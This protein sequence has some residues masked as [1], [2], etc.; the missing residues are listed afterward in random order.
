M[1]FCAAPSSP[2]RTFLGRLGARLFVAGLLAAGL[3]ACKPSGEPRAAALSDG[4]KTPPKARPSGTSSAIRLLDVRCAPRPRAPSPGPTPPELGSGPVKEDCTTDDHC[5]A[6]ASGRCLH[7]A[8]S[9]VTT[10]GTRHQIPA[11]ND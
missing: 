7:R 4:V 10:F 5:K 11:H 2:A 9:E 8:A 3:V 1:L 6:A